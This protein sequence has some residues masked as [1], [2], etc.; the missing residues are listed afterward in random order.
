MINLRVLQDFMCEVR[1]CQIYNQRE[2]KFQFGAGVQRGRERGSGSRVDQGLQ[3]TLAPHEA[4][5]GP[6]LGDRYR[7]NWA[8]LVVSRDHL[9]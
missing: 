1:R 7:L 3:N 9:R 8:K 5:L 6:K 2:S 4:Q